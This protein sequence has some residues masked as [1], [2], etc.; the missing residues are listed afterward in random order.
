MPRLVPKSFPHATPGLLERQL[1]VGITRASKWVYMSTDKN[2]PL[3]QL[4]RL[5]ELADRGL[6]TIK[7]PG[8]R[9]KSLFD[10]P[11]D[12]PETAAVSIKKERDETGLLDL[13]D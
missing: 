10:P 7:T 2:R 13:L 1:F 8:P 12:E 4:G 6:L 3:P 9:Q 5:G 11:D